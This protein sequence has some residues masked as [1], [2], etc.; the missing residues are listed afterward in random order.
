MKRPAVFRL[1]VLLIAAPWG[2]A[3]SA[4]EFNRDVRPILADKCF[5]CHG[6]DA[7]SKNIP[8]RLDQEAAAKADLGQGRRAIV[9]GDPA[10][11]VMVQRISAASP[12]QR[13]PPSHSGL[14][15]SPNEIATLRQWIAAGAK[16][17]K[18]WSFLPPRRAPVPEVRSKAWPRNAIDNFILARLEREG[19]SPSPG[20]ARQTLIRRV[21]LDLT[22][23]PPTPQEVDAFLADRSPQAYGK[24][25]D[26]LLASPRYGERMAA[27]WLD[28]A[29]YADSNGY[30][31]DGERIMWRWRD[32]VIGAFNRNMPYDRFVLEQIAGDMLPSASL[33]QILAT[34]FNRNHRANTEDGIVPEEYAVEYVVDRV[35]TTSTV[36]LGL[37][38]GCARCHNHKYDPFSQT[39]FYRMFAYFNNV[40]EL[41]RAMKYGN[42]PPLIPA[43][44]EQQQRQLASLD[45]RIG[46]IERFLDTKSGE[47][48]A[49][50]A[51]WS[52]RASPPSDWY[53]ESGRD[54]HY[55]GASFPTWEPMTFRKAQ[56]DIDDRFTLA[57][58]VTPE[59]VDNAAIITRMVDNPRGKG[60]GVYLR[61]GR[62]HVHLTSNYDDDAIRVET[63]RLISPAKSTHVLVTYDG[64][65]TAKGVTVYIDGRPSSVNVLQ[66]TL[67]RPFRN[68]GRTFSEPFRIGSGGGQD[69]KLRG[70]IDNVLV[71]SRVLDPTE[72]RAVARVPEAAVD[73]RRWQY[74]DTAAPAE[75]AAPW[76]NLQALKRERESLERTFPT[77]MV[78]AESPV[79][80]KTHLLTRGAY[81][82][83][84]E[85]VQPGVPAVL[86]PLPEG[87]PNNRLGLARWLVS[88]AN[89]LTARVA[90][91]RLW[92]MLFGTGL[93]K[94]SEDFGAQ[95]EWPSHP[96]LLDWLATE[97][98][99]TGW[100]TKAMLRLIVTSAAYMQ[101][102][103][104]SPALLQ[105]DPENRLLARG[106]R[107]RLSA[108]MVRDNAL[109]IAGLLHEKIGGP[110]VKPYQPDGLWAEITMQDSDYIQ[111]KGPDL[112][113]RSLYTFWKRTVAPP[114]LANFDAA[115]REACVVRTSRTNTPLQ[116][117]N[118]MNDVT[119]LEAARHLAERVLKQAPAAPESRLR[120]MF[121][122][123]TAREPKHTELEIL[124]ANLNYHLD[125]F[126]NAH[127]ARDY[128]NQGD[129]KPD[130]ALDQRHLAAYASVASLI[131]NL[132][133]T[134]TKE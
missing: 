34:G 120:Y 82:K 111:S 89:P 7:K 88:P 22:G 27:R 42:S 90:V 91:N 66:D 121:K 18:H 3:Q 6:P 73:L 31:Y 98:V 113:R 81:D 37:T 51:E 102:S 41:G 126:S 97:Y 54:L 96:E 56:F 70:R 49:R 76:K 133:E 100:D 95:G 47:I 59:S 30:Q 83:P 104:A 99:R 78:M 12:A 63:D 5:L 57:A 13:M 134:I 131:V 125:Y 39:E 92:Q 32:W 44:T 60:F 16:W 19:I 8:L 107:M 103:S 74:L 21:T 128:L 85:Q 106:P 68:A 14:T 87:V 20:A 46:A 4:P 29:R 80:K 116:A 26:R 35:E 43:P 75:F 62:V 129:S 24:L 79:P 10:S 17:E 61:G 108:E 127:R 23:L 122:I 105:R 9:P 119:F 48:D 109:F 110:S 72:I 36:F 50:I 118:L 132:D 53:P 94:T 65:V 33:D 77:A 67:Y 69:R 115:N 58:T 52:R 93:V 124:Q 86:H 11:S 114:M 25:V 130:P 55:A 2:R 84:A 71:Y 101:S 38:L 1:T 15:L 40:P 64:S 123:A 117:L 112:Y 45:S 28:A